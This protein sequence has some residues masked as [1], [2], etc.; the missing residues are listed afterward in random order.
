MNVHQLVQ[1]GIV[2]VL[3]EIIFDFSGQDQFD[4]FH[5]GIIDQV[6]QLGALEHV[7]RDRVFDGNAVDG[8][9]DA[10]VILDLY[11][12]G[13]NVVF[14]GYSFGHNCYLLFG[15]ACFYSISVAGQKGFV[16]C[17]GVEAHQFDTIPPGRKKARRDSVVL[18]RRAIAVS[19]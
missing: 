5:W 9:R 4:I 2:S 10:V 18:P 8:D 15:A 7:A 17:A 14:A 13:V 12:G 19:A 3:V 11:A 6:V 1:L 16:E